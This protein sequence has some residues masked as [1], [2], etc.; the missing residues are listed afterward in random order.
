[1]KSRKRRKYFKLGKYSSLLIII[2]IM[3][4]SGNYQFSNPELTQTQLAMT[5]WKEGIAFF[6]T[7][8]I[9]AKCAIESD[10]Y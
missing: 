2:G 9:F 6:I 3:L 4:Y 10:K 8:A 7:S 1:M 5:M